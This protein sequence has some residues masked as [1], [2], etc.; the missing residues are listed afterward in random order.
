MFRWAPGGCCDEP[1]DILFSS[2]S[3]PQ[4]LA[5]RSCQAMQLEEPIGGRDPP[6]TFRHEGDSTVDDVLSS[7]MTRYRI[8]LR[9]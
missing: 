5:N 9:C 7:G 3:K 4:L 6:W 2:P 8:I 1:L